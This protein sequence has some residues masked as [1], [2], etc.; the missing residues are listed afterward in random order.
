MVILK[1]K[2]DVTIGKGGSS[3]TT[4]SDDISLDSVTI[5][6]IQTSGESF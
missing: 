1:M 2:I 5:S 4:I 3:L 6:S